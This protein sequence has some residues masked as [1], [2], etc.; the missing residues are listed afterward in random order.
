MIPDIKKVKKKIGNGSQHA[1][2]PRPRWRQCP[3]RP[4]RFFLCKCE[5]SFVNANLLND[6]YFS[7]F[8]VKLNIKFSLNG[9]DYPTEISNNNNN[10]KL[11]GTCWCR[12]EERSVRSHLLGNYSRTSSLTTTRVNPFS[13]V[14][15]F[16]CKAVNL[17]CNADIK[18]ENYFH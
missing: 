18:S 17:N 16:D 15:K 2:L 1:N 9:D 12:S 10:N 11:V 14:E 8:P 13:I 3:R 7:F 4:C 6:L 5:P